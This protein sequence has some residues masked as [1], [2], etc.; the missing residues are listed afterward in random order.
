MCVCVC[1]F[2]DR[3]PQQDSGPTGSENQTRPA[4]WLSVKPSLESDRIPSH[5]N[6]G[7]R[8][9]RRQ[10]GGAPLSL[11]LCLSL[12][13]EFRAAADLSSVMTAGCDGT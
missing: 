5:N 10:T 9:F 4:Q 6:M 8:V 13:E 3:P 2:P 7:S 12:L 1:D 11:L